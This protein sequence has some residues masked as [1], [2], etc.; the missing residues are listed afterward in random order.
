MLILAILFFVILVVIHE[1]GHYLVARRNG[2]EAEE[3]GIGFPP[4]IWGKKMGRGIFRTYYSINSLPLG[5]FVKLKGESDEDTAKGSY[6]AASFWVK[7]KIILAGVLVNFF[8]AIL[9]FTILAMIGMPKMVDDQF[10]LDSK[11]S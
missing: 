7:T 2:V 3:F 6:G 9:I 10:S 4:K 11:Q 5:G 8:A 1:Y